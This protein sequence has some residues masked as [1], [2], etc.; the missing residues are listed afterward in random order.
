MFDKNQ[1]QSNYLDMIDNNQKDH[2][3]VSMWVK[4]K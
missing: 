4:I 3:G 1:I 2:C